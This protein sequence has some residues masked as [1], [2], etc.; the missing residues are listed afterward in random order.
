M[1]H[2]VLIVGYGTTDEGED[3]WIVKNSWGPRWGENGYI[4][5]ARNRDNMCGI[6]TMASYPVVKTHIF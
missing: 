6:A 3:Y 5:M 2:G 1:D 4:R